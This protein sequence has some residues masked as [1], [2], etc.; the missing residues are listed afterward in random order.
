MGKLQRII[1][2]A[3]GVLLAAVLSAGCLP[4]LPQ[5]A[6][7]AGGSCGTSANWDISGDTLTISGSGEVTQNGWSGSRDSILTIVV[8]NGITS[9][10]SYAFNGFSKLES[11]TLAD[12]VTTLGTYLC[13]SCK[14]LKTIRFSKSLKVIPSN[15]FSNCSAITK[16]ELPSGLVSIG[17]SAFYGALDLKELTIPDNVTTIASAAFFGN[18]IQSL[19][20][21]SSVKTIGERA[22]AQS[23][24]PSVVIPDSVETIGSGAIGVCYDSVRANGS[25]FSGSYSG[26]PKTTVIYG[27]SGSVAETYAKSAKLNFVATDVSAHVH[28]W[29]AW[30]TKTEA[31]CETAGEK[32]RTCSCGQSESQTIAPL[33]HNMSSWATRKAA[34]C[35]ENGVNYRTCSRCG[36]EETQTVAATGHTYGSP[37]YTWSDDNAE[38]TAERVCAKCSTSEKETVKTTYSIKKQAAVGTPGQGAYTAKFT[39]WPFTEQVRTVEIPALNSSWSSPEYQWSADFSSCTASRKEANT[40]N[41]ETEKAI[42]EYAVQ[43][44]ASCLKKGTAVYTV[45]FSNSAFAAQSHTVEVEATGHDWT[46]WTDD[47]AAGCET[48]G[49]EI[50]TCSRCGETEVRL[51]DALGHSWGGW[52]VDTKPGCETAGQYVR[53]CFR[54]G[55]KDYVP[56][57]ATGHNWGAWKSDTEPGCET[58]GK[59]VRICENC[60]KKE[61]QD[62]PARGHDWG[63]WKVTQNPTIDKEGE[64]EC[65][66]SRCGKTRTQSIPVLTSYVLSVSANEGGTVSPSGEIRVAAGSSQRITFAPNNGYRIVSVLVDGSAVTYDNG[67]TVSDV[68]NN[69]TVAVVF[70]QNAPQIVRSCIAVS[71]S[72]KRSIW[73]KD[74]PAYVINDFIVKAI[75]SDGGRTEEKDITRD[76]FTDSKPDKTENVT[77]SYRGND[78]AVAS[79]FSSHTVSCTAEVAL[80]G[81]IDRNNKVEV[82]D[83]MLALKNYVN[84]VAGITEPFLTD[85]QKQIADVD[86]EEGASL[87]DAVYILRYYTNSIAGLNPKWNE[88]IR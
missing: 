4:Q 9:L 53:S 36:K 11:L 78:S 67:I 43:V 17:S 51:S 69:H 39:K 34:T 15:A 54:C 20:L 56:I 63:E 66:C 29:S 87:K 79:Y 31:G 74:E 27:K 44:P 24:F 30:K 8:E 48:E 19:T 77:V 80:R 10:P 23:C 83:A 14:S 55:K 60:G 76:C 37:F 68:Q 58:A 5:T 52:T 1:K 71:V 18:N 88:I 32:V 40:G 49:R 59:N 62:I 72:P 16:L 26:S 21:G 82:E 46:P 22:F 3:A 38:C 85:T 25:S 47:V 64:Q 61:Y 42:S 35:T 73:L 81:D 57:E 2:R 33:G 6:S 65:K 50:R 84:D 70:Q 13:S 86:G 7:A 12:S 28:T 45:K 75:V 41:V